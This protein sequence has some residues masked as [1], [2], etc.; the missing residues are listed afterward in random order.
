MPKAQRGTAR[1]AAQK[2]AGG[3][4]LP[5]PH[6]PFLPQPQESGGARSRVPN[7]CGPTPFHPTLLCRGHAPHYPASSSQAS[8]TANPLK[9]RAPPGCQSACTNHHVFLFAVSLVG[10]WGGA[11]SLSPQCPAPNLGR[12]QHLGPGTL[13]GTALLAGPSKVGEH[14]ADPPLWH[15]K[16]KGPISDQRALERQ[17]DPL[18]PLEC[19]GSQSRPLHR[20]KGY[21]WVCVCGAG[22]RHCQRPPESKHFSRAPRPYCPHPRVDCHCQQTALI[23]RHWLGAIS[24]S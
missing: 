3:S 16:R 13:A 12:Q 6:P 1:S 2:W 11:F 10:S 21:M 20:H 8:Q 23:Y 18:R 22:E 14:P 9:V 5:D 19:P 4:L 7:T 24:S 17:M 15:G